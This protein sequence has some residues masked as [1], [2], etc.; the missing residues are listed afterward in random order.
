M[1]KLTSTEKITKQDYIACGLLGW[2]FEVFW[3]GMGSCIHNDPKMTSTTSLLMFPI[4]AMAVVIK[5]V[6]KLISNSPIVFRGVVYTMMIFIV[7]YTAGS[8]LSAFGACPWNYEHAKYNINGIVR[9][10]YAPAWFTVG[11]IY[12]KLLN[13]IQ[14]RRHA[15]KK[16]V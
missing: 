7:E 16:Q 9:L 1:K 15:D 12:E 8:I 2:C 11:L 5:P 14:S 3:T 4:Y 6:S 10:D 13:P